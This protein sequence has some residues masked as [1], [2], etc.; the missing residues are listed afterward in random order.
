MKVKVFICHS[1]QDHGFVFLLA[2]K[3]KDHHIDVWI[4]DWKIQVGDS[5]AAKINSGLGTS[6]FF[7]PVLSKNSLQ[8]EWVQRELD[9]ALMLQMT[10]KGMK[11]LPVLLD[12]EFD[13]LPPLWR[14]IAAARFMSPK[15]DYV[16]M[17]KLLEPILNARE[18]TSLAS[19]QDSYLEDI[20]KIIDPAI[21][22]PAPTR[23]QVEVVLSLIEKPVYLNYFFKTVISPIWFPVLVAHKIISAKDAPS[24]IQTG[25]KGYY[26]FPRWNVLSYLESVSKQLHAMPEAERKTC[27]RELIGII[28]QVSAE[29]KKIIKEKP[30]DFK[31]DNYGTWNSFAQILQ[32]IPVSYIDEEMIGCFDT[33]L[34]SE[35]NTLLPS[36]EIGSKLLPRIISSG[37]YSK[38]EQIS[39]ILLGYRLVDPSKEAT[40]FEGERKIVSRVEKYWLADI[41]LKRK[42]AFSLGKHCSPEFIFW[43]AAEVRKI[44]SA[45][46]AKR[47]DFAGSDGRLYALILKMDDINSF[48][49]YSVSVR[50]PLGPEEQDVFRR[51]T[52]QSIADIS[53]K[54]SCP[55][56][57][58][59]ETYIL[60]II[61]RHLGADLN[62]E[63]KAIEEYY[64]SLTV[65]HSNVWIESLY[66]DFQ[67][68]YE[69]ALS[70]YVYILKDILAGKLA[71]DSKKGRAILLELWGNGYRYPVFKRLVLYC[72]GE[73]FDICHEDV[74]S[75]YFASNVDLLDDPYLKPEVFKLLELGAE[76]LTHEE[77]CK[78]EA[79]ISRGPKR[80]DAVA[81]SDMHIK[82][83]QQEWYTSLKAIP[84][85]A[86]LAEGLRAETKHDVSIPRRVTTW[87][88]PGDS[89]LSKEE[90]VA[91]SN[92][93]IAE[94][95]PAFAAQKRDFF[96]RITDEGLA[97]TLMAVVKEKPEKFIQDLS[98]FINLP[99]RYVY[100]VL[101]GI[102]E[103]YKNSNTSLDWGN[104]LAFIKSYI[105]RDIFWE[106]KLLSG[107]SEL[108]RANHEWIVGKVAELIK[109]ATHADETA[110]EAKYNSQM[111]EILFVF[112]QHLSREYADE[113]K[114]PV[115]H[116]LNSTE[117]KTTEALLNL[118]LRC[119]RLNQKEGKTPIWNADLKAEY[120][121]LLDDKIYDAYTVLGEYLPN[122]NYLDKLWVQTKVKEF[123][124]LEDKAWFTFV[125]G[126]LYSPKVYDDLYALMRQHYVR[127]LSYDF[128]TSRAQEL[129]SQ[130]IAVGYLRSQ[131]NLGGKGLINQ[132]LET[133]KPEA[134][135]RFIGFIWMQRIKKDEVR[136]GETPE[137][138]ESKKRWVQVITPRIIGLWAYVYE[139][140]QIKR[141]WGKGFKKVNS[142]L[143]NLSVFLPELNEVN[144]KW[145]LFAIPCL[146]AFMGATFLIE[147]L[148]SLKDKGD[149]TAN[150]KYL[151]VIWNEMLK[152]FAPD[153]DIENVQAILSFIK[154]HQ[155]ELAK[156]IY[157]RYV[158]LGHE[159]VV[160]NL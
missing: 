94:F 22:N 126:Y 61:H 77:Q 86:K 91:K 64:E 36:S 101:D 13:E 76:K 131:D 109:Y 3:M 156:P 79:A 132:F 53:E 105:E 45:R 107:D 62:I 148:N 46:Y 11:I 128:G 35:F 138:A 51:D 7:V 124:G 44:L 58:A 9:A 55:A 93:E 92:K 25:D 40:L 17:E 146:E 123:E 127:A 67:D 20:V 153:Y 68:G 10:H 18:A 60:S 143:V 129:L 104:I 27:E 29:R 14:G 90:L 157:D 106:D 84:K 59:F 139:N 75:H 140:Y 159:D 41:F 141:K 135:E 152:K 19:F 97:E 151:A 70:V 144:L 39:K 100:S 98:P 23:K 89:P 81:Y 69:D 149:L 28:K 50:Q 112:I 73:Y 87:T 80:D 32:S 115:F 82:F 15:I 147:Y 47:L 158:E 160:K 116:F 155:P 150:A 113:N 83:W 42:T 54:V 6:S 4:D 103:A 49:G 31:L 16:E 154:K 65:D 21:N 34:T 71:E 56:Y 119:A 145:I 38:A 12:I 30:G 72:L 114:D 137:Q 95:I 134:I 99:Y 1:S 43:L 108:R 142:E 133:A 88:G 102:L 63:K 130:H 122:F 110:I 2:K 74:F 121:K 117:G 111:Q 24:P 78:I 48:S 26:A 120:E 136:L 125:V 8:S 37:D 5:I 96:A 85:Y 118:S 52:L 66:D 33:W 57:E